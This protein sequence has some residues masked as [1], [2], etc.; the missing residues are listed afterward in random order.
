MKNNVKFEEYENMLRQWPQRMNLVA[1]STLADI[2]TRH[3]ADS[4]QLSGLDSRTGKWGRPVAPRPGRKTRRRHGQR[5]GHG[6]NPSGMTCGTTPSRTNC[7]PLVS[8]RTQPTYTTKHE[9]PVC[10]NTAARPD[11]RKCGTG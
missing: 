5:P 6:R 8:P 1:P 3:F 7:G 10:T 9:E 4:A 11:K 2:K